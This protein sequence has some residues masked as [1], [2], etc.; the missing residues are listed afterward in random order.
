[1]NL[2]EAITEVR[3]KLGIVLPI[4]SDMIWLCEKVVRENKKVFDALSV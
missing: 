3:R 2:L 1:M 4:E